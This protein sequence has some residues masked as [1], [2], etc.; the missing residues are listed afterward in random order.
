M[1]TTGQP[2][3]PEF[4]LIYVNFRSAD[5]LERSLGSL[6]R[7]GIFGE[8]VEVILVNNDSREEALL[9]DISERF[10]CRLLP[11]EGNV[12]FARAVNR[13]AGTA[14]GGF[15]GC[16]NPD[17]EFFGGSLEI[18]DGLFEKYP[19]IGVIGAKI[20]GEDGMAEEWSVGG[21]LSLWQIIRNNLGIPSGRRLW[22]SRK[23]VS[24]GWVSGAALFIRKELFDRLSGFDERFFLYF[25]DVDLC[26][27]AKKAGYAVAFCPKVVFLHKSGMSHESRRSQKESFY[28][29]QRKYFG[30][31]RPRWEY[32][33]LEAARKI[34]G[35]AENLENKA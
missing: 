13:A 3:N 17:T 23:N 26:H 11:S 8:G 19:K 9:R 2:R 1:R 33:L 35:F 12:G 18:I 20:V 22:M 6:R 25:E 15:I 21:E 32:F 24:V 10:S 28:D 34:F 16:I 30:K 7:N 29:S 27:R 5:L 31:H 4:S 14:R